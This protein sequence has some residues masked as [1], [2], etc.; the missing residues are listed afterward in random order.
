MTPAPETA[1]TLPSNPQQAELEQLAA[2]VADRHSITEF[3]RAFYLSNF[4]LI[5]FGI[6]GLLL[7][8]SKRFPYAFVPIA[9]ISCAALAW[10]V[11]SVLRGR[12]F[13]VQEA[14]DIVRFREMRRA[15]GLDV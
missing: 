6:S 4:C 5:G 1:T 14:E 11:V 7:V 13:R 2:K 10:L 15:A 12:R 9:L 8:Q 3:M